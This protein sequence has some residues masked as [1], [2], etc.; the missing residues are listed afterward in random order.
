VRLHNLFGTRVVT[1]TD[2]QGKARGHVSQTCRESGINSE[3][4]YE[5]RLSAVGLDDAVSGL[6]RDKERKTVPLTAVPK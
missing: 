2:K 4:D 3:P 5:E 1:H 6:A